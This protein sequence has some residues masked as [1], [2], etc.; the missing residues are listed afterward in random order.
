M[1]AG[2]L[3]VDYV[4]CF[5]LISQAVVL[6]IAHELGMDDGVL[7]APAGV[8]PGRGARGVV[9]GQLR[10]PAGLPVHRHFDRSPHHSVE[11]GD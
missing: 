3:S 10:H 6:R 9:A 7:R 4:K 8:P 2:R 11:D 5:D 1:A